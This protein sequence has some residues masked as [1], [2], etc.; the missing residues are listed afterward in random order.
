[1]T[2]I[3]AFLARDTVKGIGFLAST[4]TGAIVAAAASALPWWGRVAAGLGFFFAGL[5][6]VSGGTTS[7]GA[8]PPNPPKPE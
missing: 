8:T 4:A 6:L 7:L 3:K 5:G 1:M 2:K